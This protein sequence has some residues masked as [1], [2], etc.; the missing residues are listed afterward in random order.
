MTA[1]VVVF[2]AINI[3]TVSRVEHLPRPGET[4]LARST[5]L[6]PGGKGGNA[7]AAAAAAGARSALVGAIGDDGQRYARHLRAAG[8]DDSGVVRRGD[9]LTGSANIV[10]DDAAENTIVVS[11]GA[12]GTV[13]AAQ[14]DTIRLT[15]DDTLLL[16]FELRAAEIEQAAALARDV[17]ARLIVN[18]SPWR[19]D[20]RHVTAS[21]DIVIVNELEAAAMGDLVAAE[22]VCRTLG[23]G[24]ARWGGLTVPAPRITPVDTTGAGDA[25]AGTLAAALATGADAEAALRAAV[26]AASDACLQPGAQRWCSV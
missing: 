4:V 20:L 19:D 16:Q 25:F 18:P 21:A 9:V 10:V 11:E 22:R 12:N 23:A 24:G 17:G 2:G 8:V 14:L 15:G 5:E 13:S 1:R 7:A 6:R 3:D 26:G